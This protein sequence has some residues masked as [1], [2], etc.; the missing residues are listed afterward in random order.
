MIMTMM[1]VMMMRRRRGEGVKGEEGEEF[2]KERPK[3]EEIAPYS[4][5]S[6]Q[7]DMVPVL[8]YRADGRERKEQEGIGGRGI[9]LL[10]G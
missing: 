10:A 4:T 5:P 2:V 8:C 6:K 7:R 9:L 3:E 1:M